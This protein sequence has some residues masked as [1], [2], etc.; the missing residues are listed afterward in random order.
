M[1]KALRRDKLLKQCTHFVYSDLKSAALMRLAL[2]PL[3]SGYL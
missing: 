2:H 1:H 3:Y